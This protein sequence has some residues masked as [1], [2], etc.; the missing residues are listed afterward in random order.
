MPLLA[1]TPGDCQ[2]SLSA[3]P[4]CGDLS[5]LVTFTSLLPPPASYP[6]AEQ[7]PALG[8]LQALEEK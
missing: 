2:L 7:L 4:E 1:Q 5:I 8:L 6:A 3:F